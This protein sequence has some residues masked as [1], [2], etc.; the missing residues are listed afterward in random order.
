MS[1]HFDSIKK[2]INSNADKKTAQNE[3]KINQ[4]NMQN[5]Y[6]NKK[7]CKISLRWIIWVLLVA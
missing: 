2:L 1:N 4:L 7:I 3:Q 5:Y 6:M